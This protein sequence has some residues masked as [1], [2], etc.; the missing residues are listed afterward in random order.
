MTETKGDEGRGEKRESE[1]AL[2]LFLFWVSLPTEP[3]PVA[4][5]EGRRDNPST[6]DIS[7]FL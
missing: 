6:G 4:R 5:R 7:L 1:T 2:K 3:G